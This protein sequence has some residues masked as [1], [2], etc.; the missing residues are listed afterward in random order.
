ML[1]KVKIFIDLHAQRHKLQTLVQQLNTANAT[2]SKR[3]AHLEIANEVGQQITSI[4][5]LDELLTHI[6]RLVQAKFGYYCVSIWLMHEPQQELMAQAMAG[7]DAA[8][9]VLANTIIPA[10][11][12]PSIIA[13]TYRTREL[14]L[15]KEIAS[16]SHFLFQESL[17][18]TC[19]ELALPL[20]FEHK[21]RPLRGIVG[22]L[23]IQ[24]AQPDA[25]D[26]E[27]VTA[28]QTLA[29]QISIAIR[30]AHLYNAE[31]QRRTLAESL[32][33]T[34]RVLSASLDMHEV[35][36]LVLERLAQVVPYERGAVLLREDAGDSRSAGDSA[37]NGFVHIIAQRGFPA[38]QRADRL[39]VPIQKDDVFDQLSLTRRPL[40]LDEVAQNPH[41]QQVDWLPVNHSWLG[42][43]LMTKNRVVG[44][45]SLTRRAAAAF[46]QDDAT[47]AA[48]FAGQ[49]SVALE[50]AR[51]YAEILRF[52]EELEDKVNERT[53][54]LQ[55]AYEQLELLDQNKS[56]FI[57][58]V[59][60]ELRTPL[61]LVQGYGQMLLRDPRAKEDKTYEQ[62]LT[63]IVT[64][65]LRM[66]EIVNSMLDMIRL[67]NRTWKL[68]FQPLTLSLVLES[69]RRSLAN[70]LEERNLK[71]NMELSETLPDI[72]ADHEAM[73]KLFDHLLTN[74]IKYTP[75]GGWIIVTARI[76]D[77]HEISSDEHMSVEIIISDTGIGIAPEVHDLI[78]TKFYT[79]GSVASHSTGKTKFKGGGPGLGLAI[80]RGIVEAHGGR[81]WVESPGY[82]E[83]TCPGSSFHIVLPLKQPEP[84]QINV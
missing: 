42:V 45:I 57:Q 1:S 83:A 69:L 32:E 59:S 27:D 21:H 54:S 39:R 22:V 64:G 28:L 68:D 37:G 35:P 58:V 60:H 12:T 5:D 23:D 82:D 14:Y 47:L 11:T 2:L 33:E 55:K 50:N 74:A 7:P 3:A 18:A 62:R 9:E 53:A 78:F 41:W 34:G 43:P 61:T 31:R 81:I 73:N 19:A 8:V 72:E 10:D 77:T 13:H 40:I 71:L 29:N 76:L 6:V 65:A 75:D 20:D 80:A 16:D 63:G 56:D 46:T 84:M 49:A 38:D 79:T 51:L 66:R 24:S 48:A 17:P 36:G 67:E 25:F 30:N 4:L 26:A 52:N 44:M 15:A 70:S